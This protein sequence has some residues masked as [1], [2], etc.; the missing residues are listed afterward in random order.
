MGKDRSTTTLVGKKKKKENEK[1][2][3]KEI[4]IEM[5]VWQDLDG[6]RNR[7]GDTGSVLWRIS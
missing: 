6:L 7:K 4:K 5:E 2:K 3:T 1:G